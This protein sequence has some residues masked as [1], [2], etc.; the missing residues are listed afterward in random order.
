MCKLRMFSFLQCNM[1]LTVYSAI[2]QVTKSILHL[3]SPTIR[4]TIIPKWHICFHNIALS[5]AVWI[6]HP[7]PKFDSWPE[8]V[9]L[10]E[11]LR[12]FS[13]HTRVCRS[14]LFPKIL[15]KKAMCA[16]CK[17]LLKP[18]SCFRNCVDQSYWHTC[19]L[20][21]HMSWKAT[22]LHEACQK[23]SFQYQTLYVKLH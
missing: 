18:L 19:Q 1:S 5:I 6:N 17:G 14:T 9:K 12:A 16:T 8:P 11:F 2:L 7:V 20:T 3:S 21:T 13:K 10:Q 23:S 4:S 22:R 15:F